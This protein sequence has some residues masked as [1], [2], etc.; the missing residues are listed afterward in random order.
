MKGYLFRTLKSPLRIRADI[1]TGLLD[2]CSSD[3]F[4]ADSQYFFPVIDEPLHQAA[5]GAPAEAI[6]SIGVVNNPVVHA[7]I[8]SASFL[9]GNLL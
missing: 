7:I 8:L 3:I 6:N 5:F 4:A 9:H 1:R 2:F